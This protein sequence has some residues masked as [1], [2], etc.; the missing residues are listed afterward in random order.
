MSSTV[1]VS[2][3][4][5]LSSET[6]NNMVLEVVDIAQFLGLPLNK[7]MTDLS[8]NYAEIRR[9]VDQYSN[10]GSFPIPSPEQCWQ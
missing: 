5:N 1:T 6:I 10:L 2:T 3:E 7:A 8:E 9:L 4:I